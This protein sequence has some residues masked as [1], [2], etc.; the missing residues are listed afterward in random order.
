[1]LSLYDNRIAKLQSL[2]ACSQLTQLHIQNN[3][4]TRLEG[5]GRLRSL[6]KL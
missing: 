2:Q 4:I 3:R 5:L 6:T 1:M